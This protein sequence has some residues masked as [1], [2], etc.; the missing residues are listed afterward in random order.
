MLEWPLDR[1]DRDFISTE[2]FTVAALG[3]SIRFYS[4]KLRKF[5]LNWHDVVSGI[6]YCY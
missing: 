5:N 1:R 6:D 2:A 3:N 4:L